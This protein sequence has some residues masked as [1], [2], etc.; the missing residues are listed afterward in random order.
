MPKFDP[1]PNP[2]YLPLLDGNVG[3]DAGLLLQRVLL[4]RLHRQ[5]RVGLGDRRV[6]LVRLL[7]HRR[8]D[9][10]LPLRRV[11]LPCSTPTLSPSLY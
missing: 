5:P 8:R 11:A 6:A 4:G 1:Y 3:V 2:T 10:R 7:R 9:L